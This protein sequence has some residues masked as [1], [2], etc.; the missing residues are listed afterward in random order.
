MEQPIQESSCPHRI[1]LR[2]LSTEEKVTFSLMLIKGSIRIGNINSRCFNTQCSVIHLSN[3]TTNKTS[4]WPVVKNKFKCLADLSNGDNNIVLKFCKTTLEI[5]LH[6]S[7]RNTKFCVTPL[8]I[9][10]KDHNGHFQAPNNCDNSIDT[11]C[12]KI[13]VGARLIQCLTAEKLYESGYERKTFQLER[14]INNPNEECV[15]FRSNLS[16]SEAR[17]M[18]QEELWTYFGREIMS[19]SLSS[20]KR[21]FLAFLSC[22]HWDGREKV[23]KAHAALG[24]GGL[25][26]FGT[27]CL[28]TWPSV[29]EDVVTC[30]LDTTPV[31][32]Q[33]LMDDSCYRGTFGSCFSTTLGS[34]CHELGHTFDLG[35]PRQGIMGRGF[36]NVHLV[37]VAVTSGT[38]RAA[39]PRKTNPQCS[40]VTLVHNLNVECVIGSPLKQRSRTPARDPQR[41]ADGLDRVTNISNKQV[42]E[43]DDLTYW[44]PGCAALLAFHRWFNTEQENLPKDDLHFDRSRLLLTGSAGVRVVEVRGP[45]GSVLGA[46]QFPGT[47]R[48]HQFLVPAQVLSGAQLIVAEDSNGNIIKAN[49]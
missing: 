40:T 20:S 14:D 39:N 8:Y 49:V 6:Y 3:T 15:R 22:T 4:E 45:G 48:R 32:T 7:P 44:S 46:W 26:L 36:D 23:V 21:K 19:S 9:I 16:V 38:V 13:G 37:F 27:G 34:V 18:G 30:F 5:K 11:A 17:S 1:I 28:H 2:D 31:D 10:C 33:Y 12:R 47:R 29:V 25:A 24:G 42:E 35:H 41:P 43:D